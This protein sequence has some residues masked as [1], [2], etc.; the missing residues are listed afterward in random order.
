VTRI[1]VSLP[2]GLREVGPAA[3][4]AETAGFRTGWVS[5]TVAD[6]F[7]ASATAL[8]ATGR[9]TVGT[10]VTVAF[11]RSPFA[12]A[13][14]AWELARASEGR[15]ALGLGTQVRVHAERRFSV[16]WD[17]PLSRLEDYV[18]ALR[19]I[20]DAFQKKR[21]LAHEGPYYTHTLLTDHFD[22]GPI[23]HPDVPVYLSGVNTGIAELVG[24]VADGLIA[25]P[26]HTVDYL[27]QVLRPAVARGA[28]AAGRH[29][30]DV[31]L[32]VPVWVVT[33]ADDD[34][35]TRALEAVRRSIGVF[36]STSAY[37]GVLETHGW[38]DLQSRLNAAMKAGGP[39]AAARLVPDEVI[40]RSA[41]VVEPHEVR[42]ALDARFDG[43]ADAT[44]LYAPIPGPFQGDGIR[45]LA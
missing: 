30:D 16:A 25:H 17:R 11:A 7:A 36:G 4:A 24:R 40:E 5:E 28:A 1:D 27:D 31:R 20:W 14:S 29:P 2:Q 3:V 23:D 42:T 19:A 18:Q 32:M 38:S 22:P 34:E 39:R 8:L 15:F 13:Q 43:R 21:P 37:R 9:L 26:L 35:R 10:A 45:A 12:V 33:G 41:V 44:M 6:P